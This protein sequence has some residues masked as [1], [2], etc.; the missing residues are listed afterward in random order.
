MKVLPDKA[1]ELRVK[2][3]GSDGAVREFDILVDGRKLATQKLENNKPGEF[4]H[5]T[6][7]LPRELTRGKDR[8]TV[9]FQAHPGKTAGGVFGCAMLTIEE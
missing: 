1:Q 8:L 4:Y 2:Y 5:E 6:Y 7:R 3:W 9:K